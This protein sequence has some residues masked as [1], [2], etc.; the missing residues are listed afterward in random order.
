MIVDA[1]H[2][3]SQPFEAIVSLPATGAPT[4]ADLLE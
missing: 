3:H 2:I 1:L 4:L